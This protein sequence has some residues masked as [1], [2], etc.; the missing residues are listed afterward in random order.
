MRFCRSRAFLQVRLALIGF[1]AVFSVFHLDETSL[2]LL[3]WTWHKG[4]LEVILKL[5]MT[6]YD[7]RWVRMSASIWNSL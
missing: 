2:L 4:A 6:L 3:I 1:G 5:Y 7:S